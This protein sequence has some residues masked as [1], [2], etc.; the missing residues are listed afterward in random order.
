MSILQTLYT[1]ININNNQVGLIS[2]IRTE[3]KQLSDSF[4]KEL[5][6][7]IK[8]NFVNQEISDKPISSQKT[9]EVHECIR[10]VNIKFTPK[11]MQTYLT[12]EEF[13]IYEII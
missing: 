5:Q 3:S 7:Y 11:D 8:K 12:N 4:Y 2:Y 13:K 1:G 9:L 6:E 10:P